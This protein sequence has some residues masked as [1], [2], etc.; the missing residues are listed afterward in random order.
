MRVIRKAESPADRLAVT[1]VAHTAMRPEQPRE[2]FQALRLTHPLR[3]WATW[4][5][6]EEDGTPAS[7]LVCYPLSFVRADRRPAEGYG[8]G[9]VATHPD[10]R[11]RGLARAL[12][13][14]VIADAEA[15]G[16]SLGLL[17]SAIAPAYYERLGFC[18]MAAWQHVAAQPAELAASGPRAEL[19]PLDARRE[20]AALAALY[21]RH[22]AGALHLARDAERLVRTLAWNPSNAFYGVGDPL[23]GYVRVCCEDEE[24]E[25]IELI[26]PGDQRAPVLRALAHLAA[27]L[28]L[29]RLVG[30]FA[31]VPELA[32]HLV[33][34]G[35]ATTLPMLRGETALEGAQAWSSDYF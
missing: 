29:K 1:A 8:L 3:T 9:A 17:Y 21:E 25:V 30:W 23:Q 28:P 13:E 16:R 5:L 15:S 35:R 22:H 18:A 12:C 20:A 11:R 33:D 32:A 14:H 27:A 2:H 10:L 34:E 19:R 4:W 26:V 31:P 6:L 7:S 24:L